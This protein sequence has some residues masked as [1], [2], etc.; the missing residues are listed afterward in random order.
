MLMRQA[1]CF[2][3][4]TRQSTAGAANAQ[5]RDRATLAVAVPLHWR[6]KHGS[7]R[8]AARELLAPVYGWFTEGFDTLDLK[9]ARATLDEL[10]T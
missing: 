9:E 3:L 2:L 7:K 6:C 1:S 5:S 4:L 10:A 8:D